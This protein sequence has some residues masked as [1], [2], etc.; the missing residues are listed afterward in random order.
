M[1]SPNT[2][3]DNCQIAQTK[4]QAEVGPFQDAAS[5]FLAT[6]KRALALQLND[7]QLP[8]FAASVKLQPE[9]VVLIIDTPPHK[10]RQLFRS[11]NLW[12]SLMPTPRTWHCLG[13]TLDAAEIEGE[14]LTD[15]SQAMHAL[16]AGE[17]IGLVIHASALAADPPDKKAYQAAGVSLVTGDNKNMQSFIKEAAAAGYRRHQTG[18]EPGSFRVTGEKIDIRHPL[19]P[20]TFSVSWYG[21]RIERIIKQDTRRS[22]VGRLALPPVKFPATSST[23]PKLLQD[24]FVISSQT[25]PNLNPT[26]MFDS[27]HPDLVFP[28]TSIKQPALHP[29][30]T[31]LFYTNFD[32][33][34][35][36]AN[37]QNISPLF[38]AHPL[39]QIP[40][41][42]GSQHLT[43]TS[44]AAVITTETKRNISSPISMERARELLGELVIGKPA[45][46]ADHGIG[47]YEGLESRQVGRQER[48]YL[49]LRYDAGDALAV[50]V[51]FAHKVTPYLGESHPTIHRLG[52]TLWQKT[53]KKAQHDAVAFAQELLTINRARVNRE[54]LA[55]PISQD[56]EDKLTASFPFSLTP[57]QERTWKEVKAD[58][59]NR[60]P[61][62][63]LVVGDVG[64]GKTEIAIRAATHAAGS[65]RQVAVIAPTTLLVQQHV[66]TFKNRLPHMA[67]SI[68]ELSRFVSTKQKKAGLAKITSGEAQIVIG[69]HA[70]LSKSVDWKNLGLVIIDEEQ[71]FGVKHKEHFKKIRSAIDVLSLSA[72]PIPRTLSMAVSGLRQLSVISTPPPGRQDV[73]THIGKINDALIKEALT[74]E[75]KRGGQAY[76]VAPKIRQLS[77]IKEHIAALMPQARMAVAHGQMDEAQLTKIIHQFDAREIDILVSSSI[78]EHGLD[79]PSTN[80]IIIWS[81]LLFGLADLYQ[82]RGRIGRRSTQGYA[83][84]FYDQTELKTVQRARL[85]ALVESQRQGSGWLIAQRDLEIR[86]AGN[87]L[88]KEQHGATNAVG[89][90]FYLDLINQVT[91]EHALFTSDVTLELPLS[92]AI[93]SHYI[94]DVRERT[95]WYQRLSRS[96]TLE[97]ISKTQSAIQTTY[98]PLP[99]ETKNLVTL[100]KLQRVAAQT[101]I[102]FIGASTIAPAD[103]DPYA[104]LSIKAKNIPEVLAKLTTLASPTGEWRLRGEKITLDLNQVTPELIEKLIKFLKF[105]GVRY[106]YPTVDRDF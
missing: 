100:I 30:N 91:E 88:G 14:I 21:S 103:E 2:T 92:A 62:D 38:C 55:Y 98:G 24:A 69:T 64:F 56:I 4:I 26:V 95:R 54:R 97:D 53:R 59:Q 93:P 81:S 34:R 72:T 70:L 101:G 35:A 85:T 12:Q 77:M 9:L 42:L 15:T 20:A 96:R 63:R 41:Y 13:S 3:N 66:D 32:R 22:E 1:S 29:E 27:L 68:V 5:S 44:E 79:L 39:G 28:F 94:A 67:E 7:E 23:W 61:M 51:E 65:N 18:L 47:I 82:L 105:K 16:L 71:R 90:Q 48:E 87:L 45:V 8:L 52:G 78:I 36:W 86:G 60:I 73:I 80:T 76:I 31:I 25:I 74:R 84:F 46:H 6:S 58:M 89:I 104:R 106:F 37:I 75:L 57:D 19:I 50:P 83:Y 43:L 11:L 99:E 102:T 49:M 40:F 33:A 17:N 10:L